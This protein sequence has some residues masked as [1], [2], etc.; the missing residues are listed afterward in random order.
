MVRTFI[1]VVIL[2]CAALGA[3]AENEPRWAQ[4][5]D[6]QRQVL[7]PLSAEWDNLRPWQREKMLDIARDYPRMSREQ[8]QRV[9]RRLSDWSRLTPYEREGARKQYQQFQSLPPE[10]QEEL[11]RKWRE[12][13]KL[14]EAERQKSQRSVPDPVPEDDLGN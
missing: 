2:L 6:E 11:R 4:L 3:H 1:A 12:Y 13:H 14:S 5:T 10:K 7:S 8:Q 9:Q